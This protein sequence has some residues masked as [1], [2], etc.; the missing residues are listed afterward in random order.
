MRPPADV[1][2]KSP[3]GQAH[4]VGDR[5]KF[6]CKLRLSGVC[7]VV[8][9]NILPSLPLVQKNIFHTKQSCIYCSTQCCGSSKRFAVPDPTF[10][11]A[12]DLDPDPP[13]S[14]S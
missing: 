1:Y 9:K 6:N 13:V 8:L 10:Q 2:G 12:M 4:S 14:S 5:P 7:D 3:I 11:Y